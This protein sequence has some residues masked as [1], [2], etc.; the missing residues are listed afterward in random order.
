M[1]AK[2]T[3]HPAMQQERITAAIGRIEAAAQRISA[4]GVADP[5]LAA[6]HE[7]LRQEAGEALAALDRLIAG[8]EG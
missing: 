3:T 4:R 2:L 8:L 5:G 7:A 1:L 6:R